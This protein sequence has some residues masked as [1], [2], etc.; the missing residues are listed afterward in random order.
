MS[1]WGGG[2]AQSD[3]SGVGLIS[4]TIED[5]FKF[6]SWTFVM[7]GKFSDISVQVKIKESLALHIALFSTYLSLC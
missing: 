6:E 1:L 4:I 7:T 5:I 3:F 2:R